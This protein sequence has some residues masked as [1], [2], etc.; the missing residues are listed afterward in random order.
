MQRELTLCNRPSPPRPHA[1]GPAS[2]G[3]AS[4]ELEA[5]STFPSL[6]CSVSRE[7]YDPTRQ[8]SQP[9][10]VPKNLFSQV[11]NDERDFQPYTVK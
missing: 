10:T 11:R 9:T 2:P 3:L 7:S 4:A 1:G 6:A 5:R 8:V